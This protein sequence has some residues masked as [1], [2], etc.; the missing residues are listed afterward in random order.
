MS[1]QQGHLKSDLKIRHIS[2][3]SIAGV[4]GA[5]LFI[6]SGA[7]INSSGPGAII[8]YAFAGLIVVL[9]MRMLGEMAAAN[10]TSGSFST[11]ASEA[12]G[13]WA[14][15]TIGWL[16]WF[17]WVVVIAIEA[18]AGAA[19][20][21]YWIPG[22]PL[23]LMALI[24]TV[25]LT[26]T[27]LFSVK[28]F[29]EFEYWFSLIKVVS[30]GLFL[31]IGLCV[32]F[33][34]YPGIAAPGTS[35]LIGN[36]GFMPT[37]FGSVLIG[38]TVVIFSFMGTE[39]V[40]IAAGESE[41]P[42]KSVRIATNSVVWRIL[43]FYIGSIAIVVTLLPWNSA[44]ILVS[45]FVAVLDYIG[46][47]AAA[48]IM[49]FVVLTAVLSCL[50]S[51]LYANSRMLFGMAKKGEAPKAFMKLSK[52]GVPV[53]AILFS[54]IFSYVAVIFSYI[55]PDKLFIF[56]VNS[57]GAVA[58]L[59]Y[60]VIAFSHLRMRR[61]LELKNPE[62]LQIKMW[63]FP[64]LTYATIF[65]IAGIYVAM[66]F[67]ESLRIQAILTLLVAI[68]TVGSYF[69]FVQKKSDVADLKENLAQS[70]SRTTR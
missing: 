24:L 69:V 58:L 65:F 61:Q 25:L 3:I 36:G 55:S 49:N 5:G 51:A 48:Q 9:V 12:I 39:I 42:A 66:F 6:G 20:M 59:V 52:K 46:I 70:S 37:G 14:G 43:V 60:L 57:S 11:Y 15:Y 34:W 27:N 67:I 21:Q 1:N 19:I 31:V 62:A 28:S 18:I 41:H 23:W 64:Y 17:F 22:F 63:L 13:P 56:L 32:I 33:G 50:N 4:I 26:I 68:L 40:A 54:T 8:S 7:V 53:R 29:G 30:I 45:P 47:P 10:P 38:I 44:N 16:Y 35:N 2:M